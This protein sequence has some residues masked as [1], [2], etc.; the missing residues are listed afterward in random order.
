[1]VGL[2]LGLRNW[3]AGRVVGEERR[4]ARYGRVRFLLVGDDV[5]AFAGDDAGLVAGAEASGGEVAGNLE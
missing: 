5:H 3:G 4:Q 2:T 1:M